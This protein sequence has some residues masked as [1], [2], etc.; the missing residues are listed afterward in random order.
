MI[1]NKLH[2]L[3]TGSNFNSGNTPF[4]LSVPVVKDDLNKR[5]C[6]TQT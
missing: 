2:P 6:C 5:L 3:F 1:K 4:F